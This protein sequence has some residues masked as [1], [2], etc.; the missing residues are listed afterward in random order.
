MIRFS[1]SL[2]PVPKPSPA[3]VPLATGSVSGSPGLVGPQ[4]LLVQGNVGLGQDEG[5]AGCGRGEA[6]GA[7]PPSTPG[8]DGARVLDALGS[9]RS[10][11]QGQS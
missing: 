2:G 10:V 7:L 1:R 6:E 4:N 5:R 3:T 9:A 11:R 8:G